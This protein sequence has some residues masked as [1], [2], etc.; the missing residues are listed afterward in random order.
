MLASQSYFVNMTTPVTDITIL[1]DELVQLILT[2][3]TLT[4]PDIINF[5]LTNK[6]FRKVCSQPEFWNQLA[7]ERYEKYISLNSADPKRD[8]VKILT[9]D[10]DIT[11]GS[12]E[13]MLTKRGNIDTDEIIDRAAANGNLDLVAYFY[14]KGLTL[15]YA[16]W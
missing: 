11:Y 15:L 13:F 1:P 9:D 6:Q 14:Q 7:M 16:L 3:V 8:F 4:Y 12:E 2:S 5:C 10:G